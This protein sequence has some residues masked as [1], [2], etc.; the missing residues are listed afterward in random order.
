MYRSGGRVYIENAFQFNF[1]KRDGDVKTKT[2]KLYPIK[3]M[4]QISYVEQRV[5]L[6]QEHDRVNMSL[7]SKLLV[8][9][10][11]FLCNIYN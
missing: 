9:V 7:Q 8:F 1:L 5:L 4:T 6:Y 3:D 11:L 2:D 10:Y